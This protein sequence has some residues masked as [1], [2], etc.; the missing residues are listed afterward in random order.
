[1]WLVT[2]KTAEV[3][4][5]PAREIIEERCRRFYGLLAN[6][7]S[8]TRE[9]QA[10]LVGQELSRM[11]LGPIAGRLADKR[12]VIVRDGAINYVPFAALTDPSPVRLPLQG[13]GPAPLIFDHEITYLPS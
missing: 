11:L 1:L 2:P 3:F 6:S 9:Q 4:I 7:R 12:L 5:L 8:R 10:A 13:S